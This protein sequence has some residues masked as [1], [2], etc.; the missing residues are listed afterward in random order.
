MSSAEL[1]QSGDAIVLGEAAARVATRSTVSVRA[2]IASRLA[3]AR[4]QIRLE[5]EASA[6]G[7][8]IH[9]YGHGGAGVSLSWGCADEV[10][11]LLP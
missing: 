8:L 11:E 6:D 7:L 5:A 4:P 2:S 9:S 10:R 1:G 3:H